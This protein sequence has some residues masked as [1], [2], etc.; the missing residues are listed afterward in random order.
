MMVR[1]TGEARA[2]QMNSGADALTAA[3]K[4]T[5]LDAQLCLAASLL[6]EADPELATALTELNQ[7]AAGGTALTKDSAM[8]GRFLASKLLGSPFEDADEEGRDARD[9]LGLDGNRP[10]S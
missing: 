3:I 4:D 1:P 5:K 8:A 2:A 9:G 10:A 6:S 7:L